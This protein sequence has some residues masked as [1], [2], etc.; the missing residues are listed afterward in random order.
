MNG[1][2]MIQVKTTSTPDEFKIH[3][4][5]GL[6]DSIAS[7]IQEEAYIVAYLDYKVLI[8]KANGGKFKFYEG[9]TFDPKFL[10]KMRIFNEKQEL[11]LWRQSENT[12]SAR[13]RIDDVGKDEYCVEAN[14]LLL[15]NK[16]EQ[17]DNNWILLKEARGTEIYIPYKLKDA[18][19]NRIRIKTRN[20]IDYNE[21]GQEGYVDCRF[22][23]FEEAEV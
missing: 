21:I 10:Q 22:L 15:G 19:S 17:I 11:S 3:N 6:Q 12:F 8:G 13:R 16:L 2:K 23:A 4:W 9:E 14:Q 5:Q 20:Y 7:H 1:L 18:D